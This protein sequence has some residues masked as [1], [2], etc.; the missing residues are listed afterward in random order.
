MSRIIINGIFY[1]SKLTGIERFAH[2]VTWHLDM[3]TK[4]GEVVLVL[5]AD[6]KGEIPRFQNIMVKKLPRTPGKKQFNNVKLNTYLLFHGGVCIDFT[7]HIPLVGKSIVFLHD[8]YCRVCPDDFKTPSDIQ[9]RDSTCKMYLRIAKK[10]KIVCTVSQYSKKQIMKYY[11]IPDERIEVIYN[12]VEHIWNTPSDE[13]IFTRYPQLRTREF[14]FCL[15]SLSVRKNLKWLVNHARLYP[16]EFF[17]ISGTPL[18]SVIPPELEDIR[19]LKNIL[20]VGY[21][22]D[23]EVKALMKSCKAFIFPSFFEGFGIPPLEALAC[24]VPVI[25]SNATCLPEI[26]EDCVYYINPH[27]PH[28]DLK[29]LLRGRVVSPDKLFSRYSYRK[30]AERLYELVVRIKGE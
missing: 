18:S 22:S 24:G 20:C 14:F 5:P 25:V 8:V 4:P 28:V 13:E 17:V 21:V 30:A 19:K 26:Y 1:N 23:G 27:E 9:I 10:A 6:V 15:G 7:N 11:P 2:E 29:K 12:G 3:I 16:D